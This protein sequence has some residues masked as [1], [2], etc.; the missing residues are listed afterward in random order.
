MRLL[1]MG[2]TLCTDYLDSTTAQQTLLV[3]GITQRKVK[4]GLYSFQAL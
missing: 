2:P 3:D 1:R 4:T